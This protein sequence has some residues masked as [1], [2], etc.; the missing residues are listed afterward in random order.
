[1]I[2]AQHLELFDNASFLSYPSID[3]IVTVNCRMTS[4]PVRRLNILDY[5]QPARFQPSVEHY[6]KGKKLV[7]RHVRA[8]VDDDVKLFVI[9]IDFHLLQKVYVGLVTRV[10]RQL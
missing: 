5:V 9:E 10:Y 3:D 8:V 7:S 1:M 2:S 4:I 6:L